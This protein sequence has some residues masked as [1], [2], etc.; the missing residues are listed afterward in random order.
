M[1]KSG[2]HEPQ[3]ADEIEEQEGSPKEEQENYTACTAEN[4]IVSTSH[5]TR[6]TQEIPKGT[7]IR[8]SDYKR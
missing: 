1:K 3:T 5:L 7:A 2:F 8:F 4:H 6:Y